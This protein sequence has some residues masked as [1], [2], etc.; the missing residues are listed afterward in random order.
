MRGA[1]VALRASFV[2]WG[3]GGVGRYVKFGLW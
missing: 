1:R 2:G 3:L